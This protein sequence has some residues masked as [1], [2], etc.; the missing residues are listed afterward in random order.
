VTN[1]A[2]ASPPADSA[3]QP[4]VTTTTTTTYGT[5]YGYGTTYAAAAGWTQEEL[6]NAR[7]ATLPAASPAVTDNAVHPA[8]TSDY[9]YP[10]TYTRTAGAYG[11]A[12]LR[13]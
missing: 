3:A 10:R 7:P 2:P 8:D 5:Y 11:R 13:R 9:V 4:A 12:D 6:A 1:I